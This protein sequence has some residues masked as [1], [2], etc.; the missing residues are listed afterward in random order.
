MLTRDSHAYVGTRIRHDGRQEVAANASSHDKNFGTMLHAVNRRAMKL[1]GL[2]G[3]P[4]EYPRHICS[5]DGD[6]STASEQVH[7]DPKQPS[8]HGIPLRPKQPRPAPQQPPPR[9]KQLCPAP[10]QH[11]S[12]R[13]YPVIPSRQMK[14]PKS[15]LELYH[16]AFNDVSLDTGTKYDFKQSD[17]DATGG[18]ARRLFP[19]D[20]YENQGP[21]REKW[22]VNKK[23]PQIITP[24]RATLDI[25]R[26][27]DLDRIPSESE[28][29]AVE[30]LSK[31]IDKGRKGC[32]GPDL[33]I[34]AFC[35]LDTVFF[36]G[37]LRGHVCVR[38]LPNWEK[39][40]YI[41]WGN[42]YDLGEGKSV[43]RLNAETILV[44]YPDPFER[45]FGT[46]LHS[47]W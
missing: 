10:K 5:H 6:S 45:M 39:Q 12:Q 16:D 28:E 9:L 26:H 19:D 14:Y 27:N 21:S 31:A 24:R 25:T 20:S 38:W 37:R 41:T 7:L 11:P 47:M 29:K 36:K 32:W 15:P 2:E 43:I 22:F 18:L 35:D 40:S 42:T 3:D 33:I 30:R 1:L 4:N 46:M 8:F 23:G 44:Q 17:L 13:T 34:K